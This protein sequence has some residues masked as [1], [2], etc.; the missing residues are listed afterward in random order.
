MYIIYNVILD[1]ILIL[2]KYF[3]K[4]FKYDFY[5]I[6]TSCNSQGL[7]GCRLKHLAEEAARLKL[8]E[9][10]AKLGKVK[11]KK[12][13]AAN[14]AVARKVVERMN[15]PPPA[16]PQ[17]DNGQQWSGKT[18]VNCSTCANTM[19]SGRTVKRFCKLAYCSV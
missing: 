12:A 14:V 6:H 1:I 2:Y 11:V 5:S 3:Y 15:T 9:E 18:I 16:P 13:I 7:C 19:I 4:I 17:E 10:A 8:A